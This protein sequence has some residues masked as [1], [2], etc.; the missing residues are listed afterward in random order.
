MCSYLQNLAEFVLLPDMKK[1]HLRLPRLSPSLLLQPFV[2]IVSFPSYF[3]L[4]YSFASKLELLC[5]EAGLKRYHD[6]QQLATH[7]LSPLSR[8]ADINPG[9]L[10]KITAVVVENLQSLARASTSEGFVLLL[11][12]L[13]PLFQYPE[14]SFEMIQ[15]HLDTL[16]KFLSHVQMDR[17][18]KG[19]LLHFFDSPLEPHQQGYLLSRSMADFLIRR[20]GL[21]IFL[22]K[23]LEFF[24]EAVLEPARLS[25]KGAGVRKNIFRLKESE[26]ILTLIPSDLGQ[27]LQYDDH[28]RQ[29]HVSDFTFSVDLSETGVYN[30]D[31]EYSSGESDN[32]FVPEASLLAQPGMVLGSLGMSMEEGEGEREKR[33]DEGQSLQHHRMMLLPQSSIAESTESTLTG[34]RSRVHGNEATPE[35]G[36]LHGETELDRE[37]GSSQKTLRIDTTSFKASLDSPTN[38]SVTTMN[39]G[40]PSLED[41]FQ[42]CTSNSR[43]S[44]FSRNTLPQ[45]SGTTGASTVSCIQANE[46][47]TSETGEEREGG[48]M[49]GKG[50]G[51]ENGNEG[52]RESGGEGGGVCEGEEEEELVDKMTEDRSNPQLM[53]INQQIAEIA[54]DCLCWLQRRLGPLLATRHIINPLLN[55]MH[56]CFTGILDCGGR[57]AV[58]LKCLSSMAELFGDNILLKMYLPRVEDWVGV[59]HDRYM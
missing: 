47:F 21:H 22:G 5:R 4:M 57:G 29:S 37:L 58:V 34:L 31:R 26:S 50:R 54:G 13:Y 52:K 10:D 11:L 2:P 43:T 33:D 24:L 51:L 42:S 16:G 45:G 27:S 53:A 20:F 55:G 23:F 41:S 30:S 15:S 32:E 6:L 59:S 38:S 48:R 12:H 36:S 40:S 35:T 14:T 19:V 46:F 3:E 17:L 25:T 18:F 8:H 7:P 9:I 1:T 49:E 44:P 56:R 39:L 28:K